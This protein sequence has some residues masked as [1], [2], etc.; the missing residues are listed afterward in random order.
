MDE[1][2]KRVQALRSLE[3]IMGLDPLIESNKEGIE[4]ILSKELEVPSLN[5]I[6]YIADAFRAG[7]KIGKYLSSR[8]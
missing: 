1:L 3:L 5:R 7:F 8:Y 2:S 4:S 6:R